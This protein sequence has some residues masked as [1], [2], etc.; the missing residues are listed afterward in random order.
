M[1]PGDV[2]DALYCVERIAYQKQTLGL[3]YRFAGLDSG[4]DKAAVHHG[5]HELG[6]RGYIRLNHGHNASWRKEKGLLNID[7]LS[8]DPQNNHYICP[9]GCTL[10]Y[11]MSGWI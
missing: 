8:Y 3:P 7:D 5:L 9:N 11:I 10:R 6:V 1:T 4:Y 2:T